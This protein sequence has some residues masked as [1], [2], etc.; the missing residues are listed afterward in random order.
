MSRACTNKEVRALLMAAL[1]AGNR[2]KRTKRGVTLY[3]QGGLTVGIHFT[4][5]DA[6]AHKN[7]LSEMRKA[8]IKGIT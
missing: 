2:Y 5:S 8:N 4:S 3:G 7:L 1:R 6:R